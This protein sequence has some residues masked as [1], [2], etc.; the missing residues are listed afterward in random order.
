MHQQV[1]GETTEIAQCLGLRAA[2]PLP[3]MLSRDI[4]VN[5]DRSRW[6]RRTSA[7]VISRIPPSGPLPAP[8]RAQRRGYWHRIPGDGVEVVAAFG[9]RQGHY[10]VCSSTSFSMTASGSS[11]ANRY[12]TIEP[13]TRGSKG[14]GTDSGQRSPIERL[15]VRF[16]Q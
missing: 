15:D 6:R 3:W 5:G 16:F 8:G 10:P 11:G 13:I 2:S 4:K 9:H 14:G 1:T 12:S 7:S